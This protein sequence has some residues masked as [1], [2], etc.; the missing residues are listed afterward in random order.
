MIKLR[1]KLVTDEAL[2]FQTW[3]KSYRYSDECKRMNNPIFFPRF[4]KIIEK[5]MKDSIF[6]MA[7]DPLDEDQVYGYLAYKYIDD[8]FILHF[9]YLKKKY[10]KLGLSL[11]M[12][13]SVKNN[14]PFVVTFANC[15]TDLFRDHCIY[16]P[17]LR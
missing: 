13:E 11:K 7:C 16:D 14:K 4:G 3:L 10:R 15:Y 17:S 1:N 8:L 12:L 5:I 9:I 6:V 2:I